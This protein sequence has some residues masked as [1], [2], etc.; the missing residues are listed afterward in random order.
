MDDKNELRQKLLDDCDAEYICDLV[1]VEMRTKG[2][3]TEV[4]CPFHDDQHFGNARIR[5]K[6]IYCFACSR[7]YSVFDIVMKQRGVS[8]FDA[9][10]FVAENTGDLSNYMVKGSKKKIRPEDQF[11]LNKEEMEFIGLSDGKTKNVTGFSDIKPS[12]K[13]KYNSILNED[14]TW[15]YEIY[16]NVVFTMKDLWESSHESTLQLLGDKTC[17]KAEYVHEKLLSAR[18]NDP[19]V[20]DVY[21]ELQKFVVNIYQ[22]LCK[23]GYKK[24]KAIRP[25]LRGTHNNALLF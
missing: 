2:T 10:K 24:H 22:K 18:Q 9:F 8:Y 15:S 3:V 1:G 12:G 4:L 25:V 6:G 21:E 16:E 17:E 19:G 11:P 14:G 13:Q 23:R 7:H 5:G 20:A